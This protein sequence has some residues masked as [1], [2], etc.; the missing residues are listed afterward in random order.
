MSIRQHLRTSA[1]TQ[2]H[3]VSAAAEMFYKLFGTDRGGHVPCRD[4]FIEFIVNHWPTIKSFKG[5]ENTVLW[6]S[7]SKRENS[8]NVIC[9]NNSLIAQ[10]EVVSSYLNQIC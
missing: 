5:P 3:Y 9:I 10:A 2:G 1:G 8:P 7:V 6:G 4:D